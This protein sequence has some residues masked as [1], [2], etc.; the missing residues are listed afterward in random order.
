[1]TLIDGLACWVSDEVPART[2]EGRP[3]LFLDRDGVVIEEVGFLATPSGVRLIAGA[4]AVISQANSAGLPVVI[5][6]NQSGIG[7]GLYDWD[8]FEAVQGELDRQ[9]ADA[10]ARIDLA[11]AC[12]YYPDGI[13]PFAV[14]HDWRKPGGG[15]LAKAGELL[16]L[17]LR[18]SWIVGDRSSDLAAARTAGLCGGFHVMTGH[19]TPA[20]RADSL[21]LATADFS[22]EVGAAIGEA[23][24]LVDRM[25]GPAR[26]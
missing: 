18:R 4:A 20:H 9:L 13:G 17:D 26:C 23:A 22:V 1:M 10:G 11:L 12:G 15:M 14:E 8:A 5:V 16:H 3:A 7:R 24:Y 2:F 6:T 19:G 21:A 25:K